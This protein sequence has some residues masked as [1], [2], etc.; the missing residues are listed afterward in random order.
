MVIKKDYLLEVRNVG[1]PTLIASFTFSNKS[2]V[3]QFMKHISDNQL[4]G[5]AYSIKLYERVAT[6][7]LSNGG[8]SL[9]STQVTE[10]F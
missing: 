10:D 8:L 1:Y 3:K 2:E 9:T 5:T 6:W 4:D 7:D